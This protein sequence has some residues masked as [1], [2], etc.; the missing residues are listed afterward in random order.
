MITLSFDDKQISI[1]QSWSDIRLGDYERW[2]Q[3]EPK[4]RLEQIQLIA[5]VCSIDVE[6]LLKNP[7]QIFDTIVDIVKFVFEEYRGEALNRIEVDGITYTV[8]FTEELTLAE[9]VDMESVF[10]SDSESRLSDILSILC[11]PIGES[12]DSKISEGRKELFSNL[13]MNNALPLL[14]FFLRQ[15][16]RFQNV[17]NLYSEVK[18]QADRYLLLTRNFVENGDGTKSLPIWQRIR[19][20]FLMKSL[21]KQLSKCSDFSYIV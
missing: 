19:F 14:A 11:R 1:P 16:E 17:S 4:D 2:F 5:N 7:T 3:I 18:E 8:S 10:E 15:K 12:Y 6:L 21:K 9:W 13:S 20:Y